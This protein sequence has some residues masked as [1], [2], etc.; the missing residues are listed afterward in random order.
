MIGYLIAGFVVG[1]LSIITAACF[2]M[3]STG[4]HLDESDKGID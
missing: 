1:V 3:G 2:L 4:R